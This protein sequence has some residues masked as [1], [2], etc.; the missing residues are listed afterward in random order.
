MTP[1]SKWLSRFGFSPDKPRPFP[2]AIAHRGA[3]A[4]ALENTESAFRKA[5]ALDADMWEVDIQLTADKVCVVCHNDDLGAVSDCDT[6]I[7]ESS[8]NELSAI[9]LNNGETLMTLDQV[10]ALAGELDSSLYVEIK[11]EDAAQPTWA[12]L[13]K[14]GFRRAAIGSFRRATVRELR[15]SGCDYPLSILVP[16]G[17]DPFLA[18]EESGADI[19]HLCWR[20]AGPQP[21]KLVTSDLL[22]KAHSL[23]LSVVLW[24]EERRE[25][26]DGLADHS[27]LAICSDR[28]ETLKPY[29]PN[30]KRPVRLVC[31]RGANHFAPENTLEAARMC[32]DQ[33]FDFVE[34]DVRTAADGTL[35]VIHDDTVDRTTNGSGRVDQMTLPELRSLDAGSWFDPHFA[36]QRIPTLRETLN[37]AELCGG[38]L[39]IELK[40]TDPDR[41]LNM[42]ISAGM[43]ERCF[44]GSE[45]PQV[46]RDLRRLSADARLMARRCDFPTLESASTD[47]DAQIVEFDATLDDL[48]EVEGCRALQVQSM[49]YDQTH[50]IAAL[51]R[52]KAIGPDYLNLDRPDLFKR[53][54]Q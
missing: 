9:A 40:D 37:L 6:R 18:A 23:G 35:V 54:A 52:L 36:G 34:V 47:Y 4:Y 50:D 46:M 26:L 12:A 39:Y 13:E 33:R 21:H 51:K 27:F 8:W 7:S 11:A 53:V 24:H 31:H 2:L 49:I 25:V 3:S 16:S 30:G 38:G 44:F 14:Q 45:N 15:D 22:S 41:L 43:L 28:P 42:V 1:D 32:F 5:A 19:T 10:I 17:I 48:D 29:R 20:D